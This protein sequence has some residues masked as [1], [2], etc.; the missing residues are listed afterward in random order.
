[1]WVSPLKIPLLLVFTP[2]E[3]HHFYPLPLENSTAPQPGQEG[4]VQILNGVANHE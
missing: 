2:E 3:F 4:G 1:M